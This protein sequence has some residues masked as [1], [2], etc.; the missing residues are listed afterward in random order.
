MKEF[1]LQIHHGGW[2]RLKQQ[3]NW[4]FG[5]YDTCPPLSLYSAVS[6]GASEAGSAFDFFAALG[7][8]GAAAAFLGAAVFFGLV[9]FLVVWNYSDNKCG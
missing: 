4:G 2:G 3:Q 5:L 1:L 8:L 6:V 7:F 9:A